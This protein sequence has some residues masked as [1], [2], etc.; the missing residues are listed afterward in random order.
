M[1]GSSAAQRASTRSAWG[2]GT[3]TSCGRARRDGGASIRARRRL[4]DP[5]FIVNL[6]VWESIDDLSA[7]TYRSEHRTVFARRSDWFER[8]ARPNVCMW[9]QLA[10]TIPSVDDARRRLRYLE[11]HRPTPEAFTLKQRFP[12][13]A[14][15]GRYP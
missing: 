4:T 3:T 14:R 12:P 6:T 15:R 7:F 2:S 5:L 8:W 1:P 10:G 11:D 13:P 9:W